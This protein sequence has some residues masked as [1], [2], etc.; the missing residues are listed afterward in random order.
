VLAATDQVEAVVLRLTN[1]VGAPADPRVDRW[2]LVA[3][4]LCRHAVLDRTMVLHSSGL[5]WRDFIP[6]DD[7]CRLVVAALDEERVPAGTYNLASGTSSTIRALAGVVQARVH[8]ACG[9]IPELVAPAATGAP[10]EPYV[11]DVSALG[12]LGLRAERSLEEAVDEI[13]EHCV[14]HEASLRGAG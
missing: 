14:E 2:T 8:R 9:W 4:D 7:A 11:V 1:A 3:N 6:L 5:Q 13:V 10:E 12:D